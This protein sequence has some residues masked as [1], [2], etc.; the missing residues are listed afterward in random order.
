MALDIS[1]FIELAETA[2]MPVKVLR[3]AWKL[4]WIRIG[5]RS[6]ASPFLR[7]LQ[8][9]QGVYDD[10]R[11]ASFKS[12]WRKEIDK[13]LTH[14]EAGSVSTLYEE[15]VHAYFI[16]KT[17][18]TYDTYDASFAAIVD[19]AEKHYKG[20]KT[21]ASDGTKSVANDLER[22]AYE[23]AGQYAGHRAS[24]MWDTLDSLYALLHHVSRKPERAASLVNEIETVHSSY[25]EAMADWTWGYEETFWS[26]TEFTT[27]QEMPYFLKELCDRILE[28]KIPDNFLFAPKLKSLYADFYAKVRAAR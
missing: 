10:L 11:L 22:I 9:T 15:C 26:G 24:V 20:A 8:L 4:S 23:A 14:R 12:E 28:R 7:L 17:R 21:Y 3:F 19:R 25:N 6:Q 13:P 16:A 18:P 27:S 2:G 5:S 1:H